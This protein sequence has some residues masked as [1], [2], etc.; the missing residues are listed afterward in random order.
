LSSAHSGSPSGYQDKVV[1]I[2]GASGGIGAA[3]ARAFASRGCERLALHYHRDVK[4]V[5]EVADQCRVLGAEVETLQCDLA[6]QSG[7]A[8]SDLVKRV[9]DR[10]GDLH[11]VIN[12][13]GIYR[14]VDVCE[15]VSGAVQQPPAARA[16]RGVSPSSRGTTVRAA[17]GAAEYVDDVALGAFMANWN[18]TLAANVTGHAALTFAAA[19][20]FIRK[21]Q[22]EAPAQ[23]DGP[24]AATPSRRRARRDSSSRAAIAESPR[25]QQLH[26]RAIGAIVSVGSRGAIRGEPLAWAYGASKAAMHSLA[27]SAAARL[28]RYGVSVSAVAPGFVATPMAAGA[29]AGPSGAAIA[30]QSPWGRVATP[31]EVAESVLFLAAY[32]ACPWVSGAVLDCNGASYLH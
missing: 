15:L 1:L 31:E 8:A 28:G 18:D 20:H 23:G 29:L 21:R 26:S 9:L 10:F 17:K 3:A 14:E 32:W 22:G 2:T 6:D 4:G 24:L 13:A 5:L 16:S 27:Q 12:N 7:R 19:R 30:A 25:P 11:V